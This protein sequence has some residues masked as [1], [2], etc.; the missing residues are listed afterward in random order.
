MNL[1]TDF[2]FWPFLHEDFFSSVC[3]WTVR[4]CD[5][6]LAT[7]F[8][9]EPKPLMKLGVSGG[10]WLI[11]Q[12]CPWLRLLV[13]EVS[14]EGLLCSGCTQLCSTSTAKTLTGPQSA[15]P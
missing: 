3:I 2:V 14:S 6:T 13:I 1:L 12:V 11:G 5:S 7:L 9:Q 8:L 15:S 10:V 4:L